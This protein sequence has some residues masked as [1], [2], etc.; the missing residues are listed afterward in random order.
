MELFVCVRGIQENCPS[1]DCDLFIPAEIKARRR[2]KGCSYE[3]EFFKRRKKRRSLPQC[4]NRN[5]NKRFEGVQ[6]IVSHRAIKKRA[7]IEVVDHFIDSWDNFKDATELA[8]KLDHFEAVKKVLRKPNTMKFGER[9]QFDRQPVVVNE[10]NQ[11]SGKNKQ[12]NTPNKGSYRNEV[13]QGNVQT[14]RDSQREWEKPFE[15]KKP[16]ICYCCNEVGHIKP[17][18]PRLTKNNVETVAN[19]KVNSGSEEPFRNFESQGTSQIRGSEREWER[20]FER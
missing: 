9:K 4:A 12:V 19:L 7:P 5:E 18:F 14:K 3:G 11:L 17:S 6:R 13:F 1:Q 15:R 8:E 16:I 2:E 20:P 10:I